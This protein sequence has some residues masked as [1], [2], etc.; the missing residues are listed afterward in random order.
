VTFRTVL[1]TDSDWIGGANG[2]ARGLL[3]PTT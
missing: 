2:E 1:R 3:A